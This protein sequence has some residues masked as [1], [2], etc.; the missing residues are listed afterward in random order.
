MSVDHARIHNADCTMFS[1]CIHAECKAHCDTVNF[2]SFATVSYLASSFSLVLL[3]CAVLCC[4]IVLLNIQVNWWMCC[5]VSL[6][7]KQWPHMNTNEFIV[8][9]VH[10]LSIMQS[11]FSISLK[12]VFFLLRY[13]MSKIVNMSLVSTANTTNGSLNSIDPNWVLIS[14]NKIDNE[15]YSL[16]PFSVNFVDW[17]F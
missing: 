7:L 6:L 3:S 16:I 1:S 11:S 8:F 5:T 13:N 9:S 2:L 4:I 12:V 15:I 14:K 10:S 17:V